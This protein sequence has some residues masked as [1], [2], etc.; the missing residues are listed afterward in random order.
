[1]GSIPA[2]NT[3]VEKIL[4]DLSLVR[5]LQEA[6]NLIVWKYLWYRASEGKLIIIYIKIYRIKKGFILEKR[7][8]SGVHEHDTVSDASRPEAHR[9]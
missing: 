3:K 5:T 4:I 1:M 6:E 7:N 9:W 8:S 2:D